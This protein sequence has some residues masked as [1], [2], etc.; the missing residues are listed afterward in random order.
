MG[1][2]SEQDRDLTTASTVAILPSKVPLTGR[3]DLML[4]VDNQ[5]YVLNARVQRTPRPLI[6]HGTLRRICGII[7]HQTGGASGASSL[8]S[9]TMQNAN[10]AHFLIDKDG[11]IYQ[12]ASLF[13]QTWHVGKLRARCL[14]EHRCSPT[15]LQA[16]RHFSP[17]TEHRMEMA[18]HVP[19]RYP[20]N[21]DSIGIEIA[22]A[23]EEGVYD[24]VNA[25]QNASL[26]W[27]ISEL[28]ST[29]G[30]PMTEIFRHPVVSRKNPTEAQ[31]ATW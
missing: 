11:T 9:Y 18:K 14:A 26:H 5:G 10:G 30:I 8:S 6:E 28:A 7:V 22:G 13:S 19:Q 29:F 25:Q 24:T 23:A 1:P 4:H 3:G 12:T 16:L 17:K 31:S 2:G 21:E 27:L 20:S 15:E